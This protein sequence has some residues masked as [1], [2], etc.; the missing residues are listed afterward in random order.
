MVNIMGNIVCEEDIIESG[1]ESIQIAPTLF[2]EY[3]EKEY[4]IRLIVFGDGAIAYKVDSQGS[5]FGDIDWRRGQFENIYSQMPVPDELLDLGARYLLRAGLKYGVF[6]VIAEPSGEYVF[7]E[8]NSDG[9]W[10]WLE[11]YE[12]GPM[13]RFFADRICELI[14]E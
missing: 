9:Q 12:P 1:K 2:Q 10:A 8:C 4:E 5:R 11:G 13:T 6:D 14:R 3:V 7:L